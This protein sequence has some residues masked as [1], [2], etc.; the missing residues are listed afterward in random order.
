MK[1]ILSILTLSLLFTLTALSQAIPSST[2]FRGEYY[3]VAVPVGNACTTE[4]LQ[5]R[6]Y[7]Y[8]DFTMNFYVHNWD[9]TLI[10]YWDLDDY[11]PLLFK[12]AAFRSAPAPLK[13][14]MR[15]TFSAA[16][17]SVSGVIDFRDVG[18]CLW[19]FKAYRQFRYN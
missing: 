5:V 9:E 14:R 4:R 10:F 3:G 19:T 1:K 16:T 7:V 18:D 8:D 11:N 12:N 15:G 13:S 17:G 6:I 2:Q